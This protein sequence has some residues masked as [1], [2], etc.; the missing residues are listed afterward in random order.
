MKS[1]QLPSKGLLILRC[2]RKGAVF[3][4]VAATLWILLGLY[5]SLTRPTAFCD[6]GVA[7]QAAT[8]SIDGN[9][10]LFKPDLLV[11]VFGP[12]YLAGLGI[13]FAAASFFIAVGSLARRGGRIAGTFLQRF[14]MAA[15][16][17]QALGTAGRDRRSIVRYVYGA[18]LVAILFASLGFWANVDH[19]PQGEYCAYA[20]H[21]DSY[22]FFVGDMPCR[23][24]SS[25]LFD[26]FGLY[27]LVVWVVCLAPLVLGGALGSLER[28]W[29]R[30]RT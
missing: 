8:F 17:G 30:S 15:P 22:N 2:L 14:R 29:R 20:V 11:S 24:Q 4:A 23:L 13:A 1:E 6:V 25:L 12:L 21:G 5:V 19:N 16:L 3:A 27:F 26:L 28:G 7:A 10:C 9:P 18:T